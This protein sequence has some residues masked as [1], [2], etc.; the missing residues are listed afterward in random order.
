LSEY[1][2]RDDRILLTYASGKSEKI[3]PRTGTPIA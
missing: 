1:S 3:S 2:F